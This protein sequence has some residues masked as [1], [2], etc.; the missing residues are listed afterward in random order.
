MS[1]VQVPDS[2]FSCA[3]FE[4]SRVIGVNRAEAE[5]PAAG[6]GNPIAFFKSSVSQSTFIGLSL[7]RIQIKDCVAVDVDFREAHLSEA[8]LG[9]TCL[10]NSLFGKTNLS[11]ADLSRARNNHIDPGQNVLKQA[12]FSL[13]EAM[14]L[15]YSLDIELAEEV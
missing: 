12:K 7:R 6:L 8:D 15:L 5:W 10:S 9:G 1:L 13:P 14:S 2:T 4:D 3:R 11:Q